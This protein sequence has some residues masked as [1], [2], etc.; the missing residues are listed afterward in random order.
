MKKLI[1]SLTMLICVM[2]LWAQSASSKPEIQKEVEA[3]VALYQLDEAQ[4]AKV[5]VIQER[6]FRNLA[7]IE[8]L[9]NTDEKQ[10]WH[11]RRAIRNGTEASIEML[12]NEEQM[13]VFHTQISE[14]RQK[15]SAIIKQMRQNGASKEEIQDALIRLD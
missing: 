1:L 9:K 7:E 14:R 13:K 12:L 6:R 15:E 4:T 8:V 10:Y 5:Q 11:K 3:L 2:T